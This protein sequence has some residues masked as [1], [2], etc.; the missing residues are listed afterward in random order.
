MKRKKKSGAIKQFI[1]KRKTLAVLLSILIILLSATSFF[2]FFKRNTA[3][4]AAIM[5]DNES[6]AA[7]ESQ[8]GAGES[9]AAE[10]LPQEERNDREKQ[11]YPDPFGSP[12]RLSGVLLDNE[13]K[14][15]AIIEV[16]GRAYV[17]AEGEIIAD[18]WQV[19]TISRDK[20]KM[21]S[22]DEELVLLLGR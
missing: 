15:Y 16:G 21:V 19:E 4:A 3:P 18:L 2:Y 1:Q 7:Q 20:V 9:K 5:G 12:P 14:G 13:G 6:L 10:V 17:K 11:I 22:G 8:K